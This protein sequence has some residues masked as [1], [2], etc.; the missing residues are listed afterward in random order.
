MTTSLKNVVIFFYSNP[1]AQRNENATLKKNSGEFKQ[2]QRNN[3]I[4]QHSIGELQSELEKSKKQKREIDE[5]LTL[6]KQKDQENDNRIKQ[7]RQENQKMQER[8]KSI[9]DLLDWIQI[10]F[11]QIVLCMFETFKKINNF[12]I[13]HHA[14]QISEKKMCLFAKLT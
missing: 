7:L 11:M 14:C 5:S 1:I 12:N 10:K 8:Q 6:Y 13:F 4:L 2:L 3:E 9:R